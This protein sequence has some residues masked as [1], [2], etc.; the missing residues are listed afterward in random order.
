MNHKQRVKS[1]LGGASP[2]AVWDAFHPPRLTQARHLAGM[3]K[4]EVAQGIGVSP[5]AVGQYETG[6]SKPRPDLIVGLA[7]VLDVPIEFFIAGRPMGE[8]DTS[9]A[10]FR[11]LRSTTAAQRHRALGVAGQ[12]WELSHWLER[13]VQLPLVNLPGFTGGE[14]HP[15]SELSSD[16]VAAAQELRARWGIGGGP[17][18]HLVRQLETR[19]IVVFVPSAADDQTVTIDAFAASGFPRPVMVLT[20][21]RAD[22]VYRHR[23]S[24]AHELGH[25]VLHASSTGDHRQ[26]R[27]A[28]AFAAEF[29]TPR[30]SIFPLLPRRMDLA[31]LAD[32]SRAWGVSVKSLVYRCRELGL[33]SDATT[34][35]AYQRLH[36]L[37]G[38]PGFAAQSTDGFPGEQPVMLRQAF[39][40]AKRDQG[41]SIEQ[42]SRE[43]AWNPRRVRE[44]L[45][46]SDPRPILRLV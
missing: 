3:T 7:N 21:N 16:P 9:T 25:L 43:L 31:R 11:S 4:K 35:R 39:E 42:L 24:A 5:A 33:A 13:R 10:Y 22:D 23:F 32:L 17:V 19:G 6:T 34:S 40:L 45:G 36:K 15:G 41:L 1:G 12:V 29:L 26:E 44:L 2:K 20:P 28:D 8:I 46:V 37:S 38:E 14:V 27:E 30:S 18:R